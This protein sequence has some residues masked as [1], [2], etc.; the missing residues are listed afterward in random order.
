MSEDIQF[1]SPNAIGYKKL[2]NQEVETIK[3]AIGSTENKVV[4]DLVAVALWAGYIIL[5]PDKSVFFKA[6]NIL[7][8]VLLLAYLFFR[9]YGR[10]RR[11]ISYI[12]AAD[13]Y[14]VDR[15]V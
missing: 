2:S 12:C 6:W 8:L 10:L 15:E 4:W 5:C 9:V 13:G 7:I 11:H 14:V 1:I 3:K